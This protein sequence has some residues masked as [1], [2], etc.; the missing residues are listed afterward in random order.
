MYGFRVNEGLSLVHA[1]ANFDLLQWTE[2][3]REATEALIFAN[4]LAKVRY[5]RNHMPLLLKPGDSAYLR[6]HYSYTIAG[7]PN[8]KLDQQWVGPF[9]IVCRV[10]RLAYEL[11]LTPNFHIHPVVS[12]AR[13]EPA[14]TEADPYDRP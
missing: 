4:A 5:G 10:G 1:K 11:D 7:K 9:R 3:C 14:S 8:W 13:L 12:V 6:L 2:F